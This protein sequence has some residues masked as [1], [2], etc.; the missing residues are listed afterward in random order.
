LDQKSDVGFSGV[1][2]A[3]P[4]GFKATWIPT[5]SSGRFE[6]GGSVFGAGDSNEE[7]PNGFKATWIARKSF[8]RFSGNAG[9]VKE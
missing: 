5:K 4:S 2:Y 7:F 1:T 8:G 6:S 9:F 3:F